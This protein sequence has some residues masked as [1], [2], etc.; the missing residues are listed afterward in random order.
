VLHSGIYYKPGSLKAAYCRE[1]KK[2]LEA[3]CAREGI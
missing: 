1:G 3:F 2:A